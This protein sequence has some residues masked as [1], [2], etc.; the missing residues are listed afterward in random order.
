MRGYVYPPS[1]DVHSIGEIHGYLDKGV[2]ARLPRYVYPPS[3]DVHSIGEIHG[4]LDRGYMR[5]YVYPPSLDVHSIGEIHG[6]LDRGYMWR[7][8]YAWLRLPSIHGRT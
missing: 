8:L 7:P 1:M 3:M 2:Y 6:Y 4:Y 5:G